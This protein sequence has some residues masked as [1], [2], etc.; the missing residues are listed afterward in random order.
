[1]IINQIAAGGVPLPELTN[2]AAAG[3]IEAGYEAIDTDGNIIAGTL[4]KNNLFV[5]SV[6]G[7]NSDSMT[8]TNVPFTVTRV[9]VATYLK[10]G[11]TST[12]TDTVVLGGDSENGAMFN[13]SALKPYA[14]TIYFSQSV[15]T[16][17]VRARR[18]LAYENFCS[19]F[20][21]NEESRLACE[22][23]ENNDN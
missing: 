6:R 20:Y 9:I 17:T 23:R 1:M 3:N 22:S 15:N 2:P 4:V 5:Y 19:S 7:N 12:V 14:G 16:V 21:F 10:S 8:I 13:N 11:A 18:S